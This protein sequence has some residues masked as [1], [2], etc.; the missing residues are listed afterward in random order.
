MM[1]RVGGRCQLSHWWDHY[2]WN[3]FGG[4][5]HVGPGCKNCIAQLRA[6][7]YTR[8]FGPDPV[9]GSVTTVV[10]GKAVFNSTLTALPDTDP[11]WTWPLHWK[12]AKHPV[13]GPGMPSLIFVGDMSDLFHEKRPIEI[14]DR[15]V[16]TIAACEHIGLLV[17]RRPAVMRQYFLAQNATTLE[18]WRPRMW[19][20]FSAERQR[21]FDLRWPHMRALAEIGF[22]VF[23]SI[24]PMLAPVIL[25]DDFLALAKWVIAAG[26]EDRC[27]KNCRHMDPAW[28]RELRD[29]CTDAAVPFF[30]KQMAKL[31]PIPPDLQIRQ[32]PLVNGGDLP[33]SKNARPNKLIGRALFIR[34]RAKKFA[35]RNPHGGKSTRTLPT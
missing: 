26:E 12:G 19:L 20:G 29:Q 8:P 6:S 7:V 11:R 35:S 16:K 23:V 33:V 24:S 1:A 21:E 13:L 18:Q 4:C 14:I 34:W 15:A 3:P 30:M 32:F 27:H 31:K 25:P 28:A 9:H 10:N 17:T 2:G 22:L 5:S